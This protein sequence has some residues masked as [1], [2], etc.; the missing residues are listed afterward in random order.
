MTS[1]KKFS[2]SLNVRKTKTKKKKDHYTVCLNDCV[3]VC[4]YTQMTVFSPWAASGVPMFY[5]V[6]HS[7]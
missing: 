3:R 2:I 7:V 4:V 6:I 1:F 5:V